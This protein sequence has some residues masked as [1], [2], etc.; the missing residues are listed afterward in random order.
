MSRRPRSRRPDFN[1]LETFLKVAEARSFADAARQM[2]ITQPAVSQTI[3]RLEDICGG[4]L[5]S[6]SRGSPL[7]LTP[8]GRAILPTTKL[9]LYTVDH[10]ITRALAT[11]Q[12]E[13][14]SLTI[15]FYPGLG[16][17]P[18]SAGIAEFIRSR[19]DV[20]LRLVE[21]SPGDLHR[22]LN[23]RS[24]DIMFAAFRP[25]FDKTAN[26]HERLWDEPLVVAARDD[27]PLAT[28]QHI[29][30]TELSGLPFVLRSPQG[31]L[32]AYRAIAA[33][34]GDRPFNCELHDV[35]HGAIIE[36]IRLGLGVTISF[37]SAA[38]PRDGIVFRPIVDDKNS[39]SIEAIW[40]NNDRNPLRHN[41]LACVRRNA[42]AG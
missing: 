31:D 29:T 33:R 32:S 24:I 19:P 28:Q 8:I 23:E 18:L 4:D 21:S 13:E 5:F 22:Q 6:R 34:M 10:Q 35:S 38:V 2:G 20:K 11:A 16:V 41:L 3:A 30:W 25:D 15:G 36:M 40:L 26:S 17:G 42:S 39:V 7:A 37:A 27:H 9:L 14:G 1:Q 12:S